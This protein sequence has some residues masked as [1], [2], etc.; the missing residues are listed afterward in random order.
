MSDYLRNHPEFQQLLRAVEHE[1]GIDSSLIEKDYWI[2]H[3]LYGLQQGSF[4][5]E[6]K[7]GT[8]LSKGEIKGS[9]PF[10]IAIWGH[11]SKLI[12]ERGRGKR[13]EVRS[14]R[15]EGGSQ[16]VEKK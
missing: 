6:L 10:L 8:S 11:N 13:S 3:V 1:K 4:D 7:G 2:M 16:K 15:S 14:W 12:V 5:F 9:T